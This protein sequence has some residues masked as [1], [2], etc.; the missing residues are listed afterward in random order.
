MKLARISP[1]L[2]ISLVLSTFACGQPKNPHT[3]KDSK[4]KASFQYVFHQANTRGESNAGWLLGKHSFSFN[5]YYDPERMN[6][7]VLRVLNDDQIDPGTGFGTHPHNNMEII[8]IPLSGTVEHKDNMGNKGLIQA[9]DV[10]MMSAGKG[11]T[12]SEFNHSKTDTLRL[13][14]I[15]VFP[16]K[17]NVTPRYQQ[18]NGILTKEKLNAFTKLVAPNDST[19]LF[20]YQNVVFSMGKFDKGFKTT[21]SINWKGNGVYAFVLK[22]TALVNGIPVNKRDGIGIWDTDHVSLEATQDLEILWMEVP[23]ID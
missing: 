1:A 21:Y 15:W 7:G 17:Q 14:Q 9:G 4:D 19:A 18:I 22:G 8:T 20:L 2:P 16:N 11:I 6:F 10:Q 23:M 13:L 3:D 12:H 5:E